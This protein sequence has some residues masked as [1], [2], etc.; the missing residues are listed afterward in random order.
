MK[1]QDDE[2]FLNL[3][4]PPPESGDSRQSDAFCV[5]SLGI[6]ILEDVVDQAPEMEFADT[7]A[8]H[9]AGAAGQEPP[10]YETLLAAMREYVKSQ[11]ED[12]LNHITRQVVP[13]A[14]AIATRDLAS[15]MEREL[16]RLLDEKVSALVQRSL[17]R[18]LGKRDPGLG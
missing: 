10:D 15:D 2:T 8:D 5:D 12:D 3:L 4:N 14:I 6:P 7:R 9:T 18:Q 13:Q 17:D 11:L 1:D 16:K